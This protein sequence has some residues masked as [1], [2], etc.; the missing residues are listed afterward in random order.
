MDRLGGK[1]NVY[2]AGEGHGTTFTIELPLIPRTTRVTA[3]P[4]SSQQ[5][6]AINVLIDDF[7][8]PSPLSMTTAARQASTRVLNSLARGDSEHSTTNRING[9]ISLK[10]SSVENLIAFGTA[11]MTSSKVMMVPI[12]RQSASSTASRRR[13]DSTSLGHESID[14]RRYS[15]RDDESIN[16]FTRSYDSSN[17]NSYSH[18]NNSHNNNS[19]SYSRSNSNNGNNV[20]RMSFTGHGV[21]DSTDREFESRSSICVRRPSE[22]TNTR[23]SHEVT[24][25]KKQQQQQQ[26]TT[27]T[28]TTTTTRET[29][30]STTAINNYLTPKP[31]NNLTR[32]DSGVN[33]IRK[34][35]DFSGYFSSRHIL[36]GL[37]EGYEASSSSSS[38]SDSLDASVEDDDEEDDDDDNDDEEE[39]SGEYASH[40]QK[41]IKVQAASSKDD[42]VPSRG[43]SYKGEI[44]D[45]PLPRHHINGEEEVVV[46]QDEVDSG[47]PGLIPPSV[48]LI[49]DSGTT[50]KMMMRMLRNRFSSGVEAV[51]GKDG[52]TI[53]SQYLARGQQF[54]AILCDFSMPVM[55]G[56]TAVREIRR[57]GYDGII[58]GVTGNS[59]PADVE[60]FLK[61]GVNHV[62]LK[63][64]DLDLLDDFISEKVLNKKF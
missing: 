15:E 51:H 62:L 8:R 42:S 6:A 9:T 47:P 57:M 2:S 20:K 48:L 5:S 37:P 58:L 63:P 45:T 44:E 13:S 64:L 33:M 19:H 18:N 40:S 61:A 36:E 50:R 7:R 31:T 14:I 55:D 22:H 43:H 52:V 16:L 1:I 56:P 25:I 4:P 53:V 10:S 11:A 23:F 12:S 28:T 27:T 3:E 60:L 39:V 30:Q 54:D 29:G 41:S 32:C 49:E 59:L 34:F 24:E 38:S 26:R 17:E 35:S 46:G 21:G